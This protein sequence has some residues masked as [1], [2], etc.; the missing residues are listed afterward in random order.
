MALRKLKEWFFGY[1]VVDS[2]EYIEGDT[3]MVDIT[4]EPSHEFLV[5]CGNSW[6]RTHNCIVDDPHTEAEALAAISNPGIY[7]KTYDWYTSGPRQRLQPGGSILICMTRWHTRDL[8]GKIINASQR[9]D[10]A[11]N[12]E[13]FEFP[14]ILPSGN[15]LWPE[16]WSL[17]ELQAVKAEIPNAKWQAQ[18]QQQP[19]SEESAIIKREWWQMWD[20]Q[21][22]PSNIEYV[23]MS[24]DTAFEKHNNADFSA[25]TVWGVFYKDNADD[26]TRQTNIILLDAVK[27]RVEFP[28]LKQWAIDAYR[29]WSP[30]GVI[31]EKRA[32][33][34][35]L[36]YEL[37]R[38]GIP[39]QE[40]T[41]TKGND[42]ISRLNSIAD[43][44]AS[45]F[46]WAPDTRWA[47]EVIDEVASFPAGEHDDLVDTVSQ[48]LMRFRQGGFVKTLSDEEYETQPLRRRRPYY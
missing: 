28:E 48:A 13:V 30:D 44:F 17:E 4:V 20:R 29:E 19:T 3:H 34:A 2:L 46:V 27:K 36:I 11:E 10:G 32:S 23:L 21:D 38:M 39:V 15:P 45:G 6:L 14:A 35:P 40:Y 9:N 43:I 25:M 31:I 5:Q 42:K 26:G 1:K 37:R 7:D 16:Y 8:T 22:P 33:G 47:E 12:W 41:P 24:W 18:Y